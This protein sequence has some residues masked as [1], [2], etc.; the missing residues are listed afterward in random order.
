MKSVEEQKEKVLEVCMQMFLKYGIRR[1][2]VD[3]ICRKMQMSKKTL[4][5]I[6]P[7]KEALV[8][9][10]L[11]NRSQ[12]LFERY[13]KMFQNKNSLEGLLCIIKEMHKMAS[14]NDSNLHEDVRNFYP[15]IYEKFAQHFTEKFRSGFEYNLRQGI[16]EGYYR[17]H[18]DVELL[19]V[20][21]SM[22]HHKHGFEEKLFSK[23]S[24]KRVTNF[25]FDVYV[26]FIV[27]E[28]GL[29]YYEE[30]Y[31]NAPCKCDGGK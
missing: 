27:N 26:R 8:E 1:V 29:K 11:L 9:D 16:A 15:K 24:K 10:V 23:F 28:R 2:S 22:K 17:D 4:Y 20:F 14:S 18:I 5:T 13:S 30:N 12:M 21:Q 19:T 6:Y 3:D 31:Y 25:F 7:T